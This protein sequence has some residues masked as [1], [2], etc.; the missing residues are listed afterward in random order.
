MQKIWKILLW[1]GVIGMLAGLVLYSI[2]GLWRWYSV[3]TEIVGLV[4]VIGTIIANFRTVVQALGRRST[5]YGISMVIGGL[6]VLGILAAVNFFFYRNNYRSDWTQQKTFS[7]SDQTTKILKNLGKDVQVYAFWND[8]DN[9]RSQIQ[10]LFVEYNNISPR[11]Q[12]E[13]LDVDKNAD[14]AQQVYE[15]EQ[16]GTIVFKTET[17]EERW[18]PAPQFGG[19]RPPQEEDITN[20]LIKVL[21]DEQKTVY[22]ITGHGEVDLEDAQS[23]DGYGVAKTALEKQF[24]KVS[25]LDLM[26]MDA[27]P[28]DASAVVIAGADKPYLAHE[29]AA[30]TRYLKAGGGVV[31]LLDPA[32]KPDFRAFLTPFD[33]TPDNDIV[34]D[35][36]LEN[37]LF[38]G[39]PGTPM[40]RQYGEHA[41]TKDFPYATIFHMTRSLQVSGSATALAIS[42]GSA[43]GETDLANLQQGVSFGENDIPGPLNLAAVTN[44]PSDSTG[45]KAGRLVVVGDSDFATNIQFNTQGNGNFFTNIVSWL[46]QDDDLISV[47]SKQMENRPLNMTAG[48]LR[49]VLYVIILFGLLIMG[50]GVRVYLKR[51]R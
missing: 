4:L 37:R 18:E 29:T 9:A 45:G 21:R 17:K 15:I 33:I 50:Q 3:T 44:V 38:G 24:Y 13:F 14:L 22:F 20:T 36:S 7:L 28:Q 49:I 42:G 5:K 10:E 40:V 23:R 35:P 1:V 47:S 2:T 51:R 11:F 27:V 16:Y 31:V 39:N 48:D 46:A 30:L 6:F 43:W 8:N 26:S 12:Y 41:I 19:A 25:S 34:V 32:P